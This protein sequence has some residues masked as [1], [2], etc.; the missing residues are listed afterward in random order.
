[1][2][3]KNILNNLDKIAPFFLQESFDNSGIQ[4]ADLDTPITKILLSL[5][6]TQGVLNEAIE[7]K[8]N[9]IIAHHPL[10]FSPL[11]QITKQKNPLLYQV[12]TGQ[13]NLMA[14]HT[15][16]DLAEGGLND[17]VANLLGIKKISPLQG[18]SE[19]VFKFAVYVPTRY[20]DKVGQSIFKA[21]AGKIGKYTE[22]SFNISGKGTFKPMEGT[23]PFI[24]K[25]GE[26]EEVEEIKIETVVAERNLE[27]VVQVMK[28][29]HPYE[30]P[31]YDIY[32][33]LNKPSYG[34]GIFGEIDKEVE[35]SKFSLEVKNRLQ[36]HYIRLI[37]SNNRKIK[38]VAL[39]TG[40]GGSLL[41]QVSRKD[42]DLYLTG[43]IT[44]H[45]AL[46]AKELGL[47]VLD[48]EHFDTEKFFGEA[49]YS[50]LVKSGI[51]ENILIKSKKMASPY[52]IL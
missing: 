47:N 22:T 12:I 23:N 7:K 10:L 11:K 49:L 27:S 5:D 21:G 48:I 32:E 1:M 43:D 14:M 19:K 42:A 2:K 41:E 40:S 31:A 28:D 3:V 30:E 33:I 45:T 39:C 44:Y 15:N 8:A 37:K 38:R 25:I 36:A 4:F 35:I 13:I 46:R 50:Q 34:I 9:L 17:Y 24:G 29:A 20:A 51:P 52:Q 16:Y 18:S 6:V 26:K